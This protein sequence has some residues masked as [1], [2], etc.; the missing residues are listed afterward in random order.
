MSAPDILII[1]LDCARSPEY[2]SGGS[3]G[4]ELPF[5]RTFL[6]QAVNFSRAIT[7]APWTL[8]AHDSLVTGRYFWNR[9]SPSRYSG[10]Q[11]AG[12]AA[13]RKAGYESI[14]VL[15]NPIF[16]DGEALREDFDSVFVGRWWE[17]YVRLDERA[18]RKLAGPASSS[19][20]LPRLRRGIEAGLGTLCL[21]SLRYPV[22]LNTISDIFNLS[23]GDER[24]GRRL[25]GAWVERTLVNWLSQ[26]PREKPVFALVNFNDAHEPYFLDGRNGSTH[27]SLFHRGQS[28]QDRLGWMIGNW[29]PTVQDLQSLRAA[30]SH[31]L[32]LLDSRLRDIIACF[33]KF[34]SL[35]DALI[36]VTSD[37]GQGLGERGM[38]FHGQG[39][40]ETVIRIPL[41]VKWPSGVVEPTGAVGWASLVDVMPTLMEEI[42]FA[43]DLPFDGVPL[44]RLVDQERT[45][46][47]FAVSTG[48][49][50]KRVRVVSERRRQLLDGI[51]IAG[52]L[53]PWKFVTQRRGDD[54]RFYNLG[55]AGSLDG[56]DI[57]EAS[58][59]PTLRRASNDLRDRLSARADSRVGTEKISGRLASWGY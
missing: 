1:V 7:V 31:Q 33:Q 52:Y 50:P 18:G 36:I 35:D 29:E 46:P 14:A 54:G 59:P 22:I 56:R 16:G 12:L 24:S 23:S 9:G 48:I 47:V 39:V 30:Y 21:A 20:R 11:S 8:P 26:Q 55:V 6:R 15:A 40:D 27:E 58:G 19:P 5:T 28:R 10:D 51:R 44:R 2:P 42:G 3:G 49:D 38:M 13:L 37:H 32:E 34:R 25:A 43:G 17:T 45:Q 53:G 4:P 41:M 57:E